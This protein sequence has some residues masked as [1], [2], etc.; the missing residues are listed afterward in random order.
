MGLAIGWRGTVPAGYIL[1]V[2]EVVVKETLL[3]LWRVKVRR[4]PLF[5][6][7]KLEPRLRVAG[8]TITS[9]HMDSLGAR[10]ILEGVNGRTIATV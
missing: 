4:Q 6:C 10:Q 7:I 8:N 1:V 3:M 2:Y 5:G 9:F